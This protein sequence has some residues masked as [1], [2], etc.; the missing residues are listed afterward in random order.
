MILY[1]LTFVLSFLLAFYLTPIMKEAALRFG[2]VDKPDGRLKKQREP[3]PYLGGLAI[4][5]GFLGAIS[6]DFNQQV[7]G[8]LL[9]GTIM[10]LLGLIDDF[11]FLSPRIKL[12]GQL[13]A[14]WVL[15]KSDIYIKLVFLP[16]VKGVPIV[17]YALTMFWLVGLSNAFNIIDVMDGL[18]STVACMAATVLFAVALW[19]H[20][21]TI[22]VLTLALAGSLAGFLRYN[23]PPARIYMGD[24]GSLFTGLMLGALAMIGSY[25]RYNDFAYVAPV[26]ILGVPIF[27]TFLVMFIRWRRGRPVMFGSPDHFALRLRHKGWSVPVIVITS[28]AV[29]LVLG[30]VAFLVMYMKSEFH[31]FILSCALVV[32]GLVI[33]I[34]V[35]KGKMP[36]PNEEQA[37]T[38]QEAGD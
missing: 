9:S 3:V 27:D 17:A 31:T 10:V 30:A 25:T 11:G 36:Y 20:H 21:S 16:E 5:L 19:N 29:T 24:T 15:I 33:A 12:A 22:A 13:I 14:V 8:L 18:A 26:I 34:W 23:W 2:I 35:G 32:L 4:Y 28:G 37:K 6:F 38:E 1:A 7:L